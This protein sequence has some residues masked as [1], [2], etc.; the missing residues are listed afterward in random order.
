MKKI[1]I[2]ENGKTVNNMISK[3]FNDNNFKIL[4]GLNVPIDGGSLKLPSEIPDLVIADLTSIK[5]EKIELLL[6]LK[7][8]PIISMVPFLLITSHKKMEASGSIEEFKENFSVKNYYINKPFSRKNF[9][10][11]VKKILENSES[12]SPW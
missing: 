1:L 6:L 11:L 7:S 12:I 9:F 4:S 8:N 10:T 3:M 5:K 2:L